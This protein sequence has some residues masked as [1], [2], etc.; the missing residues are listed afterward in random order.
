[1]SAVS[2]N[3]PFAKLNLTSG[4]TKYENTC[5]RRTHAHMRARPLDRSPYLSLRIAANLTLRTQSFLQRKSLMVRVCVRVV[6]L[7][8][9]DLAHMWDACVFSFAYAFPLHALQPK[10]SRTKKKWRF[11]P[12]QIQRRSATTRRCSAIHQCNVTVICN[13]V[14][15]LLFKKI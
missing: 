13:F 2:K 12:P 8:V 15:L 7:L 9:C 1:M 4:V 14:L 11:P 6:R 3:K 5:L 10:M